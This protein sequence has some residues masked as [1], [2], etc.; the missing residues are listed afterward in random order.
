MTQLNTNYAERIN[1]RKL[2]LGPQDELMAV[3]PMKHK[4]AKGVWDMMLANTWFPKKIDLS[5]DKQCYQNDLTNEE[6]FAYDK[7]LAF[8]SNLDGIQFN[9][10]NENI[11][12]HVTSNEVSMC[13]SRQAWEEALHV[14][15]YSMMIEAVSLDPMSVYMT[16]ERDGLLAEKN[17]FILRQSRIIGKEFTP[18]G[19]AL[20]LVSNVML[21]GLYFFTGFLT[22]YLLAKQG[23]MLGSADMIRYIQRDEE[24]SHLTLFKYMIE[25]MR[26][27]NPE[28]FTN[29]FE[30]DALEIIHESQQ[31]EA[32]WGKYVNGGLFGATDDMIEHYTKFLANKRAVDIGLP[33]LYSDVFNPFEWA[34]SFSKPNGVESNFFET[35]ITAYSMGT[36]DL[37]G[38]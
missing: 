22:F 16:F 11:A 20:A 7:A 24:Q 6:R 34:E 15:S 14:D 25:T 3:N 32:S 1:A 12:V 28:V 21:E 18:R 29:S 26:I 23:K 5:N 2:I 10:I 37:D 33:S 19:F 13:L 8:L 31:L 9:N 35:K 38:L 30:S 27:E 17:E 36:L 4:W